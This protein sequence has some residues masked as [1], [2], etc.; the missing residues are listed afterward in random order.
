MASVVLASLIFLVTLIFVIWQP[1]NLSIGWSACGGAI[2]A[3]LAGVVDFQ[4]VL[5]VTSIVWNA[6]L[7]FIAIIIISLILDEIGFFEWAALHMARAA[8][9]NGVRMFVYVSLLGAV[10]AALF[11]N[12]GAALILTPIVLAMVRALKFDE[13]MVFPFIIASGFIADTTSLPLVVSNLVNIVSADFFGISFSEF[14]SRMIVPDL[15]S[16]FA[17]IMVLYVYFRKRIPK[18]YNVADLQKPVDAIKDEKMFRLSGIVLVFLVLGYLIGEFFSVPVSII[19]GIIAILFLMMAKKS[20]AV[21]TKKVLK[22]A[23]WAIVFFSIGMYVVVYGLRN[24]GLTEILADVI[25]ATASHGLFAATIGMGFTAAILSS[26][27]NNMPTV[28]IDALAIDATHAAGTIKEALIYANVIGS[29]LGPKI[30][31]IGSLATLLWLHVLSTKGVK[32]S[33]GT[34]LK[35]GIILTI[36]TLFITL[37][38][39][40]IW[41]LI[42]S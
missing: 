26:I 36:P 31:P 34:Y 18:K 22:G 16:L 41:L 5:E 25:Q 14:A 29:D 23:P 19:A 38:G 30:T 15:V 39:L 21:H 33:W 9:G 6:T 13:K 7:T 37:V 27:M 42:I 4:D 12:D 35:T 17:S 1:K 11:A 8:G 3:L 28:M 20:R 10:V 2:L 32:I 40:Y 24:A